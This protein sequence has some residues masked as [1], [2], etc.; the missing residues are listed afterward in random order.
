M[1]GATGVIAGVAVLVAVGF[2]AAVAGFEFK[3]APTAISHL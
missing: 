1:P 2:E 3:G